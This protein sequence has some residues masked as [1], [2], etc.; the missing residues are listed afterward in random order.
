MF[1]F[2]M[3]MEKVASFD[4]SMTYLEI[5]GFPFVRAATRYNQMCVYSLL[6]TH[7]AK[8]VLRLVFLPVLSFKSS[9]CLL[10]LYP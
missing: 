4:G 1:N 8:F 5:D 9:F 7:H 3:F 6:G 10:L 2:Q